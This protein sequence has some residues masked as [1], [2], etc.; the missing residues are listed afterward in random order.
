MRIISGIAKSRK[1]KFP[2]DLEIRPISD[3][4][5]QSLFEILKYDIVDARVLDLFAG[6]GSIGLEAISRGAIETVFVD[7]DHKCIKAIK[8]N[9]HNLNFQDK[10]KVIKGDVEKVLNNPLTPF[11]KGESNKFN[12]IILD[13]PYLKGLVKKTL[14][15]L[16]NSDII[17]K[18]GLIVVKHHKKELIDNLDKFYIFKERLYGDTKITLLIKKG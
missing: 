8:E 5:K 7:N 1:I 12:I 18:E 4:V 16:L 13:P 17:N 10:S 15:N 9:I 2:S 6:T 3:R 14:Q 11:I